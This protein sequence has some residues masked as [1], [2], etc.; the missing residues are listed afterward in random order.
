LSQNSGLGLGRLS[1]NDIRD[2]VKYLQST[3][4]LDNP[5][6]TIKDMQASL[7]VYIKDESKL[8]NKPTFAPWQLAQLS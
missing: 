1:D 4:K 5:P 3:P 7:K 6:W 8:P 2:M